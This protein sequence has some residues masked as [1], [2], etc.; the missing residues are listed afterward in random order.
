MLFELLTTLYI[1]YS[2][3]FTGFYILIINASVRIFNG[4]RLSVFD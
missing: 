1:K 2:Q 4:D 3:M